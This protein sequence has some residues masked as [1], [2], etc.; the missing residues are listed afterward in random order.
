MTVRPDNRLLDAP[1]QPLR[2]DRCRAWLRVRKSSQDQTSIQWDTAAVEACLER[3][4]HEPAPGPNGAY[5]ESCGALHAT[6]DRAT[7]TGDIQLP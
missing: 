5:F 2:C 6:I 4:E 3:A 7:R 1:M